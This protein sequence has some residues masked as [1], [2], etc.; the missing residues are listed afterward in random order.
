MLTAPPVRSPFPFG[1]AASMRSA[2]R[3]ALAI[4]ALLAVIASAPSPVAAEGP[5]VSTAAVTTRYFGAEAY[6]AVR[7]AV[8]ATARSCTIS[9]D[10]LTAMV[11]APVFKE[12]SAATTPSTAPS[13]MTLSR[14]DEWSGTFGETSNVNANYGLYAFRDPYTAY[15]RAYWHPGIGIWQYDSAGLGA[16]FTTVEAMDVG[17]VTADVAADHVGPLLRPRAGHAPSTRARYAAWTDWGLP[18]TLC[19]GFYQEMVSTTPDFANLAWCPGSRRSV[20]R[21]GA[22][23]SCRDRRPPCPAGTSIRRWA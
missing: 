9:D 6:T 14:Y 4:V 13:P 22:R 12:S 3:S 21:C 5:Q 8:A 10:A 2:P 19:E 15:Q 1:G 16:P 23:A 17:V 11:L 20:A 18:C 7:T